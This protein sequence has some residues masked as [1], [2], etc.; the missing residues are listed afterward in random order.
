VTTVGLIAD[1]HGWVREEVLRALEGVS[2]IIH[3]GDVGRLDVLGEL[4]AVAPVVAV[5]GNV[6]RGDWARRLP[7]TKV[8]T[9]GGIDIYVLHDLGELELDPA[10][11]GF[12]VVVSGHSH[13]PKVEER[14][15]VLYVNPGSAGPGR[16][17][18]PI[19][20]ARLRVREGGEVEAQIVG[21]EA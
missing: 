21:L 17:H 14:D 18:L 4:R 8:V 15:G 1:T 2:L 19:T 12:R 6:D 5:R 10:A 9:A 16:F 13:R 7:R 11:A 20:V 3:A